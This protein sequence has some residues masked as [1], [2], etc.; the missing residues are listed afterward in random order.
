MANNSFRSSVQRLLAK[1]LALV[2]LVVCIIFA[3]IAYVSEQNRIQNVIVDLARVQIQR[4]N[5]QALPVFDNAAGIDKNALQAELDHFSNA[6]GGAGIRDGHF[7]LAR[8]YDQDR[9]ALGE[10]SDPYFPKLNVVEKAL[11]VAELPPLSRDELRVVTVRLGG[12]PFVGVALPMLNSADE[13]V[14]Q[15]VGVFAVSA[16]AVAR[17][18][19]DIF[20]TVLYVIAI[21]LVTAAAVYP[22]IGRLLGRLAG[23]TL[24]L[25]DA[26][27]ET[28]QVLGS[29]IAKRDS[30]TDAHNYRVS[31]YSVALAE[32]IGSSPHQI[33]G[34]I[35]GALLHDV[36]K[37]GIRDNVLLKP[38]KLDR[39][40]FEIMKT[41]VEHGMDI[42][43]RAKWLEDARDV[44]GGHHEKFGGTGYPKG[45]AGKEIPINARI[46]AIVDVFDAL[47]SKRPYKD[48]LSFDETM[49]IL[50]SG[51]DS[52]FDPH[53]LDLFKSIARELYAEYGGQDSDK[54]RMRLN[55]IS[56]QYFKTDFADLVS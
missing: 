40:E 9:R 30:D 21:V 53:L 45:L 12:T 29:A 37:L 17:I 44:V 23:T 18:R 26:N 11:D 49:E 15:L 27:L 41:H 39:G 50:E 36:G 5:K 46:F 33:Q 19:G 32:A 3:A 34:L 16:D 25:L 55:T 13:V 38:G 43:S 51:R 22:I 10:L 8:V 35:K 56:Q 47:T 48:P 4:F 14:G 28:M 24:N 31:V 54:P 42:T 1:R 52:H 2:A 20:R 6:S 7:V